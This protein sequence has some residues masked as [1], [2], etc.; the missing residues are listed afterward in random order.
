M[1][2][3]ALGLGAYR[4][5]TRHRGAA[6]PGPVPPDR[7]TG[8][9]VWIHA[10]EPG[11]L[12][13]VLDLAARLQSARSPL[14]VVVTLPEDPLPTGLPLPADVYVVSAPADHPRHV[15]AFLDHWRPGAGIW[16][17]GG[18]RPDLLLAATAAGIALFL[19]DAD[20]PGFDA[21]RDRWLPDLTRRLLGGFA[22]V[23]T[24]SDAALTRLTRLGLPRGAGACRDT[25]AGRGTGAALR[26][27]GPA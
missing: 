17:W 4:A 14:G 18:L 22:V 5:L 24:R 13:A 9:V 6:R 2:P 7:P 10:G 26:R 8:E 16:I 19:I 21:R 11:N 27:S 3:G 25:A 15:A 12:P 1:A 23:L 20:A